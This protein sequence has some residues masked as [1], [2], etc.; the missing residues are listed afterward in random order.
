VPGGFNLLHAVAGPDFDRILTD[1]VGAPAG[2][3]ELAS[4]MRAQ[5]AE[6]LATN[7]G[8]QLDALAASAPDVFV[9]HGDM[10]RG[11]R[12]WQLAQ[13]GGG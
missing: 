8:G 5:G 6:W 4:A 2:P 1:S 10:C 11:G 12:L 3:E 7:V 9:A 13:G